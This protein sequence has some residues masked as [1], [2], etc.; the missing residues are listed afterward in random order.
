MD[1][2]PGATY[3]IVAS[4]RCTGRQHAFPLTIAGYEREK[5]TVAIIT[6]T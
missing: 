1:R 6:G 5:G 2:Q 3:R 4:A